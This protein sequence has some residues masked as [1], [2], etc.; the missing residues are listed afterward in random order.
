LPPTI[1]DAL[2]RVAEEYNIVVPFLDLISGDV[3]ELWLGDEVESIKRSRKRVVR[4][5]TRSSA[6][7]M[8]RTRRLRTNA[9]TRDAT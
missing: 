9:L 6:A 3:A 2:I 8:V 1:S 7:P 4:R 5:F